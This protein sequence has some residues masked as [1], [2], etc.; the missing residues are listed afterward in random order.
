MCTDRTVTTW[1]YLRAHCTADPVVHK[2]AAEVTA[3]SGNYCQMAGRCLVIIYCITS[4]YYSTTNGQLQ[5][6]ISAEEK[7]SIP[8]LLQYLCNIQATPTIMYCTV[9][10]IQYLTVPTSKK[11]AH[12]RYTFSDET[13]LNV[14]QFVRAMRKDT[15]KKCT[16]GLSPNIFILSWTLV[17]SSKASLQSP[18][19]LLVQRTRSYLEQN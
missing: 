15:V 6:V 17:Q 12:K 19:L 3:A 18:K 13:R 2:M 5:F 7:L 4:Y 11:N 14:F 9:M 16:N 8:F 1:Q 10:Y